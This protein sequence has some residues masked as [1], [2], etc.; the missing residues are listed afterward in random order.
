MLTLSKIKKLPKIS[1]LKIFQQTNK[2]FPPWTLNLFKNK[3]LSQMLEPVKLYLLTLNP[4]IIRSKDLN[5]GVIRGICIYVHVVQYNKVWYFHFVSLKDPFFK[6][7]FERKN[8]KKYY[9]ILQQY[10]FTVCFSVLNI[11]LVLTLPFLLYFKT[12]QFR[13]TQLRTNKT[14]VVFSQQER[15]NR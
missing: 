14:P 3:F 15:C 6:N 7:P 5:V 11:S 12:Y 4:I 10:S 1:S 9:S 13:V 2:S 8:F